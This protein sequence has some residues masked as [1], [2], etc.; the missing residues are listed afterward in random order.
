MNGNTRRTT[1]ALA[2]VGMQC[3]IRDQKAPSAVDVAKCAEMVHSGRKNRLWCINHPEAGIPEPAL[4]A[5]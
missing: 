5:S 3:R 1:A 4:T 2:R